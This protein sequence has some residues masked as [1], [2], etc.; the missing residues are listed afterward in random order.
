MLK[1]DHDDRFAVGLRL[2]KGMK[3]GER[4]EREKREV[5]GGSVLVNAWPKSYIQEG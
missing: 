1:R 4:N 2:P 3:E 5:G